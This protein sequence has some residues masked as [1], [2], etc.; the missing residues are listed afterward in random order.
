MGGPLMIRTIG[1]MPSRPCCVD[2]SS[3]TNVRAFDT[4]DTK[5]VTGDIGAMP[6]GRMVAFLRGSDIRTAKSTSDSNVKKL[7][8][9]HSSTGGTTM[10]RKEKKFGSVSRRTLLWA[11]A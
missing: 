11:G 3:R 2:F 10:S 5:S 6:K 7:V 9:G 4:N 1:K 8:E